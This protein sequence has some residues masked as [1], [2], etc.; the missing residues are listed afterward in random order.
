MFHCYYIQMIFTAISVFD[1][2]IIII[3]LY[4]NGFLFNIFIKF[5]K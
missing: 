5:N 3:E 1:N 2:Y 4:N